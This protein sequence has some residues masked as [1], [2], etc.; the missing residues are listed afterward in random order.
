MYIKLHKAKTFEVVSY[1]VF[2]FTSNYIYLFLGELMIVNSCIMVVGGGG[3][4]REA[5][6]RGPGLGAEGR[7]GAVPADELHQ[8]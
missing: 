2:D 1:T 8:T 4:W 7:D 5:G 6:R 3:A